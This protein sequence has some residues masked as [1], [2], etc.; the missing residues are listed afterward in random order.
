M[1]CICW[2]A[3]QEAWTPNA[4]IVS[5]FF[6]ST[7]LVWSILFSSWCRFPLYHHF[8]W[9]I[10]A[11]GV[12]LLGTLES[13]GH[14]SKYVHELYLRHSFISRGH[15]RNSLEP[16]L[17]LQLTLLNSSLDP[18]CDLRNEHVFIVADAAISGIVNNYGAGIRVKIRC[19]ANFP[20][21]WCH[22][23]SQVWV[24]T[25]VEKALYVVCCLLSLFL[26]LPKNPQGN[27]SVQA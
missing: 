19:E 3:F 24:A 8:G 27:S 26:F 18:F 14:L 9:P 2:L 5:D 12:C 20:C 22:L 15:R 23:E 11:H 25:L 7:I 1:N 16:F 10:V 17:F 21:L 6:R 13:T 4:W